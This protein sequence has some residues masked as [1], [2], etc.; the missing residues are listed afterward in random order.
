MIIKCKN[1]A[2]KMIL[3]SSQRYKEL[4]NE[5]CYQEMRHMKD[6]LEK[7]MTLGDIGK[8]A[9]GAWGIRIVNFS[10]ILTQSGFCVAYFI[11]MGNTLKDMFP[12]H[13][14]NSTT[15][16]RLPSDFSSIPFADTAVEATLRNASP[17][18]PPILGQETAPTFVLLLLIPFP[19]LVLMSFIR[20][21]RKLGPVSGVANI[22]I[23]AGFIGLLT[24]I[25]Q[26]ELY[27]TLLR[28]KE[29]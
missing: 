2:V 28:F 29:C 15:R 9:I 10:L 12:V 8:I 18:V 27:I 16:S 20:N 4:Q 3:D 21:V 24:Y 1:M 5:E 7:E 6:Q 25:L 19:F 23:L 17:M 13:F 26:G 11:F 14:Y 22:A